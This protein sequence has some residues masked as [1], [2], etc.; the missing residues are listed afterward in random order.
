MALFIDH[1]HHLS[2]SLQLVEDCCVE[3]S[4]GVVMAGCRLNISPE[5]GKDNQFW[6]FTGDGIIRN[7]FK[8][9]LVMEVKGQYLLERRNTE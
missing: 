8:P 9:D 6:S 7:N 5:P 3:T 2:L 1:N 4:G